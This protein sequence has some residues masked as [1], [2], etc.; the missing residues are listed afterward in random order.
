MWKDAGNSHYEQSVKP[1]CGGEKAAYHSVGHLTVTHTA[2]KSS[3]HQ[4]HLNNPFIK[5]GDFPRQQT[6][7]S[8]T[9]IT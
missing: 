3:D 6:S 7:E 1:Q 9:G 2:G 5:F 8:R 4:A